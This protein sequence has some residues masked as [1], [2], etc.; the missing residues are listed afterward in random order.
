MKQETILLLEDE[1]TIREVL[2]EYILMAD[3]N[4]WLLQTV[5]L[6]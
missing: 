3:Y 5:M 6:R 1:T 4:V 2:S